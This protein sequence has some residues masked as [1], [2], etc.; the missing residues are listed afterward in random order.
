MRQNEEDFPNRKES[1]RKK[2]KNKND[3]R[4]FDSDD[5]IEK[6]AKKNIDYKKYKEEAEE[7]EWENWDRYYNH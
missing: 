2:L 1:R 3:Y 7:E 5:P 4:E 6:K